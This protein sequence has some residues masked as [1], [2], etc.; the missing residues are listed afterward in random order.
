VPAKHPEIDL[1]PFARGELNAVERKRVQGHL[2]QCSRCRESI[3]ELATTA[4]QVAA[5]LEDLPTPEWSAYRRELRLK[6]ARRTEA[7][8]RWWRPGVA[9]AT[10]ATAGMG[11]AALVLSLSMRQSA[12]GTTPAVDQLAMEQPAEAVDVGLLRNY[13]VVEKLDLLEDYDVIEHLD[14]VPSAEQ[15]HDTR[16]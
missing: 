5:H 13:A 14:E 12:P 6:L 16:S 9:W 15:H 2:D 8:S 1:L 11:F 10:L 3:D 7:R 4:R